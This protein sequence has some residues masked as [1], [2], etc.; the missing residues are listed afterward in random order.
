M[1]SQNRHEYRDFSTPEHHLGTTTPMNAGLAD[2]SFTLQA[3]M[4]IQ[5]SNGQLTEAVSSLRLSIDKLDSKLDRVEGTVSGVTHKIY[6]AG[7][8]LAILVALGGFM[9]NKAW[10]LMVKQVQIIDSRSVPSPAKNTPKP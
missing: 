9:V 6:A 8:V 1:S 2:H 4:D 7:V 3:I 10:D 5:K